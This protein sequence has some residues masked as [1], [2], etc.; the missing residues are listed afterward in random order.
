MSK[1]KNRISFR[2]IKNWI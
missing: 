2:S 1:P